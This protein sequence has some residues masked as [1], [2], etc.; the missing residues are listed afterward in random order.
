MLKVFA[1]V[2]C[3]YLACNLASGA[4][5]DSSDESNNSTNV[6]VALRQK[7]NAYGHWPVH[8]GSYEHHHGYKHH[9]H[10]HIEFRPVAVHHSGEHH[11]HYPYHN[12]YH[13]YNLHPTTFSVV[14]CPAQYACPAECPGVCGTWGGYYACRC[15]HGCPLAG[16]QCNHHNI[17]HGRFLHP[18]PHDA[19]R[20]IQCDSTPGVVYIRSCPPH[21]VFDPHFSVCNYPSSVFHHHHHHGH[22]GSYEHHG[23][24]W[25]K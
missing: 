19:S 12:Y 18:F 7:R 25:G 4:A 10:E 8:H 5:I 14:H 20:Y 3:F 9:S 11:L 22:H 6:E 1:A 17:A 21:L 15:H 13:W 23:H 24:H 16:E 2:L